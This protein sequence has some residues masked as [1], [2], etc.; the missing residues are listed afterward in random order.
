MNMKDKSMSYAKGFAV[1]GAI[2]SFNECV[3]EKF[4]AKH[5]KVNPTLAG[6][7]TG[8]TLAYGAGPKAMCVG[9]AVAGSFSLAIEHFLQSG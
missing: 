6:C 5:D 2:Y 3:I 7:I 1:F 9:C 8:A 4:R